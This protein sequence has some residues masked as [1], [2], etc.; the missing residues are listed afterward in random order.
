MRGTKG[1]ASPL[2]GCG[3]AF[4]LG[5]RERA[6]AVVAVVAVVGAVMVA[7]V[8]LLSVMLPGAS[9]ALSGGGG[10]GALLVEAPVAAGSWAFDWGRDARPP[11]AEQADQLHGLRRVA[12]GAGSLVAILAAMVMVGLLRQRDRLRRADAALRWAVGARP[13]H[14]VARLAGSGWPWG[15]L[16]VASAVAAGLLVPAFVSATFPGTAEVPPGT[17]VSLLLATTIL[18]AVARWEWGVGRRALRDGGTPG[19][20]VSSPAA[21]AAVGFAALT[22]VGLLTG[23]APGSSAP[24]AVDGAVERMAA[25]SLEG[26]P[27]D[28]RGAALAL[29][30]SRARRHADTGG[31]TGLASAGAARGAGHHATVW[32]DCGSCF[33]GGLPMPVRTVRAEVHAVASDTFPLLGIAVLEGRDFDDG[34]DVGGPSVAIVSRALAVRHFESGEAVGRS[35]RVGGSD[36]LTVVGVVEDAAQVGSAGGYAVYLPVTQAAPGGV[37]VLAGAGASLEPWLSTAPAGAADVTVRSRAEIFSVHGWFARVLGVVGAAAVLLAGVGVWLGARAE[38][39]AASFEL[40][41]RRALGARRVDAAFRVTLSSGRRL[42]GALVVGAWLSLFLGSALED[43]Y[44]TLPGVDPRVWAQGAV[45]VV[46]AWIAGA[47][48]AVVRALRGAPARGLGVGGSAQ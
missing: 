30:A 11:S 37:E 8:I 2:D 14:H 32:V 22:G 41:L 1:R 18:V 28:R 12:V 23:P 43:A 25:V 9:E 7:T 29:W 38:T 33:E 45:V 34:L 3:E 13:L 26:I 48:P 10:S 16:L 36:W 17:A 15:V 24:E 31:A 46:A 6:D 35:L 39:R 4:L 20:I 21:V 42:A 40:A 5:L 19:R 47:L 44:G 27:V